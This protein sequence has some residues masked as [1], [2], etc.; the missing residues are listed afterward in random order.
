MAPNGSKFLSFLNSCKWLH[1]ATNGSK[2]FQMV[3]NGSKRLQL[4]LM[5]PIAYLQIDPN[6]SK[7]VKINQNGPKLVKM[8]QNGSK[9]IQIGPCWSI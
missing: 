3:S 9:L 8:R 5:A 4:A 6:W 1:M 7:W 2:W